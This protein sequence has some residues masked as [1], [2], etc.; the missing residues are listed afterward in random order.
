MQGKKAKLIKIAIVLSLVAIVSGLVLLSIG[1][2]IGIGIPIGISI[3]NSKIRGNLPVSY[4]INP[5]PLGILFSIKLYSLVMA[6]GEYS[7]WSSRCCSCSSLAIFSTIYVINFL[8][9]NTYFAYMNVD[10]YTYT[11]V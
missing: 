1:G 3:E 7:M 4:S 10:S 2:G 9:V 6:S 8:F 5:T 11:V